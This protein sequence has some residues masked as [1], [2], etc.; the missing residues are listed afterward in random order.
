MSAT[1]WCRSPH[2]VRS[3]IRQLL[4]LRSADKLQAVCGALLQAQRICS[5][6]IH[7]PDWSKITGSA[8]NKRDQAMVSQVNI[9]ASFLKPL[10]PALAHR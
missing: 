4:L 5:G 7:M 2:L 6:S 10:V 1:M 9:T 3:E 8:I